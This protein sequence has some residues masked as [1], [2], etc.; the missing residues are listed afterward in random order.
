MNTSKPKGDKPGR[1]NPQVRETRF[2]MRT[3]KGD[4]A[5]NKDPYGKRVKRNQRSSK[6]A[7]P[8]IKFNPYYG[9]NKYRPQPDRF[10]SKPKRI[11]TTAGKGERS[12]G[13]DISG[14]KIRPTTTQRL[15]GQNVYSAPNPYVA[16]SKKTREAR[17]K[18]TSSPSIRSRTASDRS[19]RLARSG[20]RISA[21]RTAGN[22]MFSRRSQNAIRSTSPS[23]G[24]RAKSYSKGRNPVKSISGNIRNKRPVNPFAIANTKRK[25]RGEVSTNKDI[26][27][28]RLKNKRSPRQQVV[29]NAP[30][31]YLGRRT[32][33]RTQSNRRQISRNSKSINPSSSFGKTSFGGVRSSTRAGET[34]TNKSASGKNLRTKN[35]RSNRPVFGSEAPGPKYLS[36]SKRGEIGTSNR[37]ALRNVR[38][39]QRVRERAG[40]QAGGFKTG[41]FKGERST[42]KDIAGKRLRTR[43]YQSRK[44]QI[45]GP[46]YNPYYSRKQP[47]G[48][49]HT[50]KT[51]GIRKNLSISGGLTNN[52]G[53]AIEGKRPGKGTISGGRF[54]GNVRSKKLPKGG[55]SISGQL[56]NNGGRSIEGKG[57]G[58]GTIA[59]GRFSGNLRAKRK[60]QGGGSISERLRNNGGRSIEGKAPG[61]GTIAGGRFSGN[62]KAERKLKGG[63]SISDQLRNNRGKS[64]KGRPPGKGTLAG[65]KYLGSL[66][67]RKPA[68]G[69][70]SISYRLRNNNGKALAG[71]K[72]GRG[73]IQGGR[74][75]GN[76]RASRE[77]KGGGSISE[78]LRN[79]NGKS[80]KGFPPGKGTLAGGR[81][82]G[83]IKPRRLK[84]QP[85]ISRYQGEMK[86]TRSKAPGKGAIAG[87]RYHG[88]LRLKQKEGRSPGTRYR[89]RDYYFDLTPGFSYQGEDY[90]GNLRAKKEKNN[91]QGETFRGNLRLPRK[92]GYKN[93]GAEYRGSLRLPRKPNYSNE[94]LAYRGNMRLK[95]GYTQQKAGP[96]LK[97]TRSWYQYIPG[98]TLRADKYTGNF[99]YRKPTRKDTHISSSFTGRNPGNAREE[100]EKIFK[101]KI[102][103]AKIFK[104]ET[105]RYQRGRSRKARYD[106]GESKIW[107]K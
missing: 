59:G 76:L 80:L 52:G 61:K 94:G 26:A 65:G 77:L 90:K 98:F 11:K 82:S 50:I 70:G 104:N 28:K 60:P 7:G 85:F 96:A 6:P 48:S 36:N 84:K 92:P 58:K 34:A 101:F 66:K 16:R 13:R 105:P 21:P 62:L 30:S 67:M 88:N 31:P 97:E 32:Q 74:F 56:R 39:S 18:F 93:Q 37:K 106:K 83:N 25:R 8:N 99:K 103:W 22:A 38:T 102:W 91:Y 89:G 86:A 47:E 44:T 79:N 2:K 24:R 100:N 14:R 1:K 27:G 78:R 42:N 29:T 9:R 10:G 73:T 3:K 68:K 40:I 23:Q 95:K 49:Q 81:Y 12:T 17:S 33:D 57:P 45:V 72:P 5:V 35:M 87:A 51:K 46:I 43:N 64:L 69:G 20:K 53:K 107:Y 63:G 19:S 55:G 54:S 41:T 4:K 75:G 71:K 15:P